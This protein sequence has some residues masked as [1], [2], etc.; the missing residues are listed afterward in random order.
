M[1]EDT[2][3][4]LRK[5]RIQVKDLDVTEMRCVFKITRSL[6]SVPNTA[7]LSIYNLNEDHRKSLEQMPDRPNNV[8]LKQAIA[9]PHI[10]PMLQIE[11]GYSSGT[12]L[13]YLGEVRTAHSVIEGAS[14]VTKLATG[15][16][17]K[18]Q[19]QSRI[20][21]PIGA[22]ASIDIA[23]TA[24]VSALG[25]GEGNLRAMLSK[26]KLNDASNMYVK[27][28]VLSGSASNE[29]DAFCKSANLDWSI[30][31][32]Q[33][34]LLNRTAPIATQGI[35]L[36]SDTGLIESPSIDN[37]GI[38]SFKT[39]MIPNLEP[40]RRVV[41]DSKFVKGEYRVDDCT[42]TGDTEGKEWYI[43]CKAVVPNTAVTKH[44]TKKISVKK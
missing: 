18:E 14:I 40:G 33:L 26:V 15:D 39:L 42:Y 8:T 30:Q 43:D 12:H 6:R 5:Y 4:F 23:L 24:L 35:V 36:N 32:G 3:L 27:G 19:Q 25:I 7:E 37:K 38:V 21:V 29:M 9:A 11:A 41:F 34:L 16:G 17:E 20:N 2:P 31:N 10:Y 44:S 13:L 1:S 22:K 28:G